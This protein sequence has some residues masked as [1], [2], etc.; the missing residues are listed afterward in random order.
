M[1]TS[2]PNNEKLAFESGGWIAGRMLCRDLELHPAN[3]LA[4]SAE[5]RPGNL[6]FAIDGRQVFMMGELRDVAGLMT[7]EEAR[8]RLFAN[9]S[10]PLHEIPEVDVGCVLAATGYE[11]LPTQGDRNQWQAVSN[12]P[13]G[14]RLELVAKIVQDGVEIRGLPAARQA[15]FAATA[16]SALLRFLVEAQGRIRFAR[17]NWLDRT[18][19]AV[20][21]AAVDRLDVELPDSVAAVVAACRLVWREVSALANVA[22]AEAYLERVT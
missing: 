12:D 20:S 2:S 15:D 4:A 14:C 13:H 16:E 9:T 1:P 3:L 21:L 18:F 7:I 22:V 6:R 19:S 8:T 11:W 10:D 17:F 5:P